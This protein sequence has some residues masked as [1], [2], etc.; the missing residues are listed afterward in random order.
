MPEVTNPNNCET[1][2]HKQN[3]D[4]GHCYMFRE[5]PTEVCMQHTGRQA[6]TT[7][8]GIRRGFRNPLALAV[9]AI[10]LAGGDPNR[11]FVPLDL[12]LDG[13]DEDS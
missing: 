12:G 6:I 7:G 13:V 8:V 3:P 9:A 11:P 5:A 10:L 1:C 2:D 4:G